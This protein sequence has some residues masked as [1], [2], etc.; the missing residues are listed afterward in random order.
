M[1]ARTLASDLA[2]RLAGQ[3]EAVCAHYLSNGVREGGYWRVGDVRNTPGR[4]M[5]VRLT[6]PPTGKGA[7]GKWTDAA[8]GEHGDLLDVIAH[9]CGLAGFAAVAAEARRFL[10]LPDPVRVAVPA[11]VP[12][13][14]RPTLAGRGGPEGSA[15]SARRLFA[16][17]RPLQGTP[18]EAYLRRRAITVLHDTGALRFH[19][20]CHYRPGEGATPQTWPALIAA[21]TD[22]QGVLTGVQRTYLDPAG[23]MSGVPA[24]PALGKAPLATPRRALGRL[25]GAAVRF[26]QSGP[27]MAVGEGIET[28]LSL[29]CA[30]PAL[31]MAAALSA[32]NLAGFVFPA[33]LRRL[34]VAQDNDAAGKAAAATL[35]ARAQAAGIEAVCLSSRLGDF[36]DDLRQLGLDAVLASIRVQDQ[37]LAHGAG[38]DLVRFL[39]PAA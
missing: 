28:V 32:A 22:D 39:T 12:E 38:C 21:L 23:T 20:H 15:R 25:R 19:P 10:C 37:A 27:V 17:A 9:A 13:R 30:L 31:S 26:G 29:R 2:A 7:A 6:G 36:N 14:W 3:A 4:S 34:Y 18:G 33:P 1:M 5:F 35:M 16:M 24:G 11:S 8:T